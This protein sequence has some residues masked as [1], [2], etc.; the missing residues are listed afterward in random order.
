[1]QMIWT[2][3]ENWLSATP[4]LLCVALCRG[5]SKTSIIRVEKAF[6][7]R[8]FLS[9]SALVRG[10]NDEQSAPVQ[11]ATPESVGLSPEKVR[12]VLD[13]VRALVADQ[14]AV[15]A[16]VLLIK[17]GKIIL[18]EGVGWRDRE[19]RLKMEPNTICCVR[20]M[21]KPVVGTAVQ[22]LIDEGK[23]ALTDRDT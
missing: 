20:S 9:G 10:E 4:L 13:G 17:D 18:D 12:A 23:L 14:E 3:I 21:T 15:R 6:G 22:M 5:A 7:A 16:Q 19:S 1:M 11:R 2:R 8:I